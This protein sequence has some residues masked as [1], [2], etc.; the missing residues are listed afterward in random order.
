MMLSTTA[1]LREATTIIHL[2]GHRDASFLQA[3]GTSKLLLLCNVLGGIMTSLQLGMLDRI[4]QHHGELRGLSSVDC[5][6]R[7]CKMDPLGLSDSCFSNTLA[8]GMGIGGPEVDIRV[9]IRQRTP[10]V[11]TQ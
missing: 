10:R 2:S 11:D 5:S 8:A 7:M 9:I 3:I 4:R 1:T 6:E